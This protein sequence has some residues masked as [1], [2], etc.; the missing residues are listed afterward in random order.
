MATLRKSALAFVLAAVICGL[1][2]AWT[3]TAAEEYCPTT[4]GAGAN[5]SE[6][7][8]S[9]AAPERSKTSASTERLTAAT[10]GGA[11]CERPREA[12]FRERLG[13]S[14]TRAAATPLYLSNCAFLR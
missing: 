12:A 4:E 7:Q 6:V 11:S 2:G 10:L 8:F 1:G 14:A 3:P 13:R 9:T 5:L